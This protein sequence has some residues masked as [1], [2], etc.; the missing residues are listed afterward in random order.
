MKMR[1]LEYR[2][3]GALGILLIGLCIA[4]AARAATVTVSWTNPTTNTDTSSIPATGDG[5]LQA[6]RIEYGTC[7]ASNGFGTKA[8][9]V[10]RNRTSPTGPQLTSTTLNLQPSTTCIRAFVA[11][12]YNIES[13]PS[14]VV[15]K[16]VSPPKP[17]PVQL[18]T[19]DQQV[20]DVRPNERTFAFDRGR[21]VGSVKL[22]AA[23]DEDRTTGGDFYALERPSRAKLTRTPRSEALVARCGGGSSSGSTGEPAPVLDDGRRVLLGASHNPAAR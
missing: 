17:G 14:N 19:V 2:A 11:N 10:V 7:T 16:V 8:G 21:L 5:S 22:G 9:E 12:T 15:S 13:D 4:G 6:W 3:V 20:F 23:C 18:T 1:T